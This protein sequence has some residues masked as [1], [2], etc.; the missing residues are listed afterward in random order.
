MRKPSTPALILTS[1]LLMVGGCVSHDL[2]V[3]VERQLSTRVAVST[4]ETYRKVLSPRLAGRIECRFVPTC[5]VYGLATVKKHGGIK[6]GLRAVGR[7]ARC[8]P[9]TP[10]GTVDL[11]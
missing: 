4:I 5:S 1:L 11:P 3:P 7:I 9:M 10:Q 2:V 6:G 8:N